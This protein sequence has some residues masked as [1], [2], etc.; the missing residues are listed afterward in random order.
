MSVITPEIFYKR[1]G[2][3]SKKL[4]FFHGFGQDHTAFVSLAEALGNEYTCYVFD[5]FFH[6]SS[7]WHGVDE[8]PL[9]KH[10]WKKIIED[11]L[12]SNDISEFSLLGYSLGAKFVFATLESFPEKIK[13]IILDRKS[14]RLNSSH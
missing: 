6:G 7:V 5:L 4:L 8:N 11:I 9:E 2:T 1:I 13:Q 12:Q 3:G 10:E 14:T